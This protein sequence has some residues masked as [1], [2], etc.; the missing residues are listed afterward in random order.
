LAA[1]PMTLQ[2]CA[3]PLEYLTAPSSR[4]RMDR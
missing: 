3:H 4:N 1:Q 2:E